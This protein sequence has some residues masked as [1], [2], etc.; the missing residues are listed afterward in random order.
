MPIRFRRVAAV[1]ATVLLAL[2]VVTATPAGAVYR[3]R[4]A[5]FGEYRFMASLRL[6]GTP[7]SPRC[8][9]TLIA[10]DIVLTA[11]HC[12]ALVPQGG[13]VVVV[14]ADIPDWP[15][16]PRI[17]T[18]GHRIPPAFDIRIDN[19]D[20]IAV[21]RLAIPQSGPTVALA[22]AE[23]RVRDHVLIAGFG[24]VN[25]PPVCEIMATRLQTSRQAVLGDASCGTDVFANP[26]LWGPTTICTKGVRHHST[27]NRGDSGGPL[28]IPGRHG[29]RQV[30]VTSL[31]SDSTVK[32]YAGF[33]S[34]P[35]EAG[36]IAD[37]IES[38][39]G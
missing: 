15:A 16:A 38:L 18:L 9:G 3:G 21:I 36:W 7:D 25:A 2:P 19:R 6:A 30:G 1:L 23:P 26:P 4:D 28:L 29:F 33:T 27:V 11:A 14:G 31:G 12:V 20:D 32:R 39:R 24:C 34:I 17:P 8:G 35:V 10:P 22:T 5:N 13:L 37:A